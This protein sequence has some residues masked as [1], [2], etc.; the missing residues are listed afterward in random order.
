MSDRE[1]KTAKRVV[2]LAKR[3]SDC[4][5]EI[6]MGPSID[7]LAFRNLEPL[8]YSRAEIAEVVASLTKQDLL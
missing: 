7:G 5:P 4:N 1:L 2:I 6:G 8:G 3:Y